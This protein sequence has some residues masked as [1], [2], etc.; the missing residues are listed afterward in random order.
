M[1]SLLTDTKLHEELES[2]K[3]HADVLGGHKLKYADNYVPPLEHRHKKP[4]LVN[5]SRAQLC[6]IRRTRADDVA[7]RSP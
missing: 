3:R 5:V 4:T 2:F 7:S 1:E 6:C